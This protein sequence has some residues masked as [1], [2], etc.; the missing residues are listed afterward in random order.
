MGWRPEV[1]NP[2]GM[3][4]AWEAQYPERGEPGLSCFKGD[5]SDT[6][7]GKW[8]DAFFAVNTTDVDGTNLIDELP[9]RGC[10]R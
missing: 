3:V 4:S 5:M 9:E 10:A 1:T 7:P 6:C 8:V 2:D